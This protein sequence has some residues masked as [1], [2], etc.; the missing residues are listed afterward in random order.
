MKVIFLLLISFALTPASY[1][2]RSGAECQKFIKNEME[3][4]EKTA[5]EGAFLGCKPSKVDKIPYK[6]DPE[7]ISCC[8]NM[9][10]KMA[11]GKIAVTKKCDL[12]RLQC[13]K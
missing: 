12:S 3:D 9:E 1:A 13:G 11:N 8:F 2:D 6:F 5:P 10:S 4:S 7:E